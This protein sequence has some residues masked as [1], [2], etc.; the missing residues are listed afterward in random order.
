MLVFLLIAD[1]IHDHFAMHP[2]H[3]YRDLTDAAAQSLAVST[4][5][6]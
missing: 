5:L 2:F 6:K 4:S 3:L 1:R